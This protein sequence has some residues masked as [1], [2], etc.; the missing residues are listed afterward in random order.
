MNLS[1]IFK[2]LDLSSESS[3]IGKKRNSRLFLYLLLILSIL[4]IY[5]KL[6]DF[7]FVGYDDIAYITDNQVV[8]QG[9]TVRGI[10]LAFTTI[11]ASNWHPLTWLS[12]MLDC[13]LF[14]MN[15]GMHHLTSLLIHITNSV[16][17]MV[18]F[19]RMTHA[20]WKSFLIALLF[21]IHP[22]HVESVAWISE[23]K[24][25]LSALFWML[26]LL[27]YVKYAEK[28]NLFRYISVFFFFILGILS[29]PMVVTLPFVLLILDFWPLERH[30][31]FYFNSRQKNQRFPRR[32]ITILIFEKIPL[33]ALALITSWITITAQKMV[34]GTLQTY[35]LYLRAGNVI[36]SYTNYILKMVY[37]FNLAVFYPYPEAI[38]VWKILTSGF[39]LSSI[40][41]MVMKS[42]LK[43]P[44][45]VMGWFCFLGTLIP[46]IGIVQVGLQSM[47]DRYSYLPFIGLFIMIVWGLEKMIVEKCLPQKIIFFFSGI[48]MICL[49][50]T[51]YFQTSHWKN[52]NALFQ[53]AA[54]V[55]EN[56]W[57]AY[58]HYGDTLDNSNFDERIYLYN[59]A[60]Q[61]NPGYSDSYHSRGVLLL[62]HGRIEKAIVNF[63]KALELSPKDA[64]VHNSLGIAMARK[65]DIQNAVLHFNKATEY[66]PGYADAYKNHGTLLARMGKFD[67][68]VHYFQRALAF[69][70]S[71]SAIQRYL[72]NAQED[73]EHK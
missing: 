54:E 52:S 7:D 16:L 61:L 19:Y 57:L 39:I 43:S 2:K 8:Q 20:I 40:T 18:V 15:P 49:M 73:I 63:N 35:P 42:P 36:V 23:R 31:F 68:A 11:H 66:K 34:I 67:Q 6:P 55:V 46:V 53:H 22:M 48:L 3:N 21:G 30:G 5:Q 13:Q 64:K 70:P 9:I 45:F 37:P 59:K 58:T 65:N 38:P 72:Q 17:L 29:K 62:N 47:A 12:H 14:G 41:F 71:N 56:N 27:S 33:L 1:K 4:L 51:T 10:R 44:Y 32:T 28:P 69:D 25:V 24:D 50:L 60:I 26:T